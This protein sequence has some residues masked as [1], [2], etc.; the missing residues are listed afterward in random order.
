MF[1]KE[2]IILEDPRHNDSLNLIFEELITYNPFG[3]F[4]FIFLI[5][6]IINFFFL[7]Y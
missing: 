5:F 3:N 4:F 2:N 1:N 7:I 6:N